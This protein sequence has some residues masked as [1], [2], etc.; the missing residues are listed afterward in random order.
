MKSIE[1]QGKTVDQAIEIGLYKLEAKR[2][3]VKIAI[4]EE[5]GLFT[6]ARVRL[7]LLEGESEGETKVK[8][9][10]EDLLHAMNINCDIYVE[11]RE[12]DFFIDI[13]GE[14]AALVIGKRGDTLDALQYLIYQM[15][16]NGIEKD[17]QKKIVLDSAGYKKR[18]EESLKGLAHRTAAKAA[19]ENKNIALE[20]MNAFERK[21]IHTELALDNRVE[22][23]SRGNEPNRYIV[24]KVKNKGDKRKENHNQRKEKEE[25]KNTQ[26]PR[27]YV[28]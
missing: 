16:N 24:I 3:D 9:I 19:R 28:D 22:T 10:V 7:T 11:E 8:K 25:A 12:E 21:I 14:D 20:P 17:D 6:K 2:E 1:T 27:D 23:E 15:L 5:A 4:L 26:S 13:T 18:R